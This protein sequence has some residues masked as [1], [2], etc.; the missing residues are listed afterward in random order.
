MWNK[1]SILLVSLCLA[2]SLVSAGS[3]EDLDYKDSNTIFDFNRQVDDYNVKIDADTLNGYT[4]G[5]IKNYVDNGD[6][7]L[8]NKIDDVE[9]DSKQ[10]DRNLKKR[11]K[12]NEGDIKDNEDDIN[13]LEREVDRNDR[14]S[15]IRDMG[16]AIGLVIVDQT[17][18]SRD[19]EL[20]D[21]IDD[22][23]DDRIKG[24][25]AVQQ[26]SD[27]NDK[28]LNTKIDGNEDDSIKRDTRISNFISESNDKWSYDNSGMDKRTL[29]Y[30]LTGEIQ[31]EWIFKRGVGY[32]TWLKGFFVQ[33]EE[34]DNTIAQLE[35]RIDVLEANIE[36]LLKV[37]KTEESSK[38]EVALIT[39]DRTGKTVK[40]DGYK[41]NSELRDCVS[42]TIAPPTKEELKTVA[43][44]TTLKKANKEA[45][46][47]A[48]EL[49]WHTRLCSRMR[50]KWHCDAM[51][52]MLN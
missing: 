28:R 26:Y 33:I 52:K 9:S 32:F 5:D 3:I 24:D 50:L 44:K 21:N 37:T 2:V 43:A 12:T 46:A 25:R 17:S 22:E 40:V 45:E 51:E 10:R 31:M 16:L 42:V 41:C 11:I 30:Y 20:Q 14:G 23:E 13:D 49:E 6:N 1:I 48:K 7:V 18:K 39:S 15:K 36:K 34:Y 4:S 19:R 47:F 38:F 35:N 29:S 27:K 8:D